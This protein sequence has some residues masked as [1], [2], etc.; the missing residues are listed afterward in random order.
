MGTVGF[1]PEQQHVTFLDTFGAERSRSWSPT[2][3]A[4]DFYLRLTQSCL[5]VLTLA[6]RSG[7]PTSC[8]VKGELCCDRSHQQFTRVYSLKAV[9]SST[10]DNLLTSSARES[11]VLQQLG[12][13]REVC[14]T[15]LGPVHSASNLVCY[16]PA[17]TT[18]E[19]R[20]G[21][22][23]LYSLA[24]PPPAAAASLLHLGPRTPIVRCN[25][26]RGHFLSA[27]HGCDGKGTNEGVLGYAAVH[28]HTGMPRK[29]RRCLPP[30]A[31]A[32]TARA[33]YHTLDAY[34]LQG[35]SATTIGHV[36]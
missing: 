34:C 12:Q 23:L 29:L 26:S 35:D 27:S 19:F 30:L 10:P 4:G 8:V 32:A 22:F 9:N 3:E 14:A 20:S 31:T 28:P 33:A 36:M 16:V 21:P 18:F 25:G 11:T 13:Y 7:G 15:S 24:D 2:V 17:G 5:R 1:P 6:A